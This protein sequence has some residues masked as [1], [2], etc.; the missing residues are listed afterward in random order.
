MAKSVLKIGGLALLAGAIATASAAT[1]FGHGKG[2]G[3]YGMWGHGA[4]D[5][6][7]RVDANANGVLERTGMAVS[8]VR[9][10]SGPNGIGLPGWT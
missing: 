9:S 6:I 5:W 4:H 2:F 8:Q 1:A 10:S 3:G 7:K